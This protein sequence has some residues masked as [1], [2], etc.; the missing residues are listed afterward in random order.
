MDI[1]GEGGIKSNIETHVL[2]YVKEIARG[3]L[4]YGPKLVLC[5]NL[6]GW[7]GVGGVREVQEGGDTRIPMAGSC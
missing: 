6:E 5:D 2:P 1:L 3:N 7:D 4:M